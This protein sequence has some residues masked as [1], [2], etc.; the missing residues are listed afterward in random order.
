MRSFRKLVAVVPVLAFAL[1]AGS[2]RDAAACGGC[3]GPADART[4]RSPPTG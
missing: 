3:F 4:P 2:A 1:V